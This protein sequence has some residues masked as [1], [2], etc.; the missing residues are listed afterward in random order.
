[1]LSSSCACF[2]PGNQV[3]NDRLVRQDE[4]LLLFVYPG[5]YITAMTRLPSPPTKGR[6]TPTT[7][8]P[9]NGPTE[10]GEVISWGSCPPGVTSLSLIPTG[11]RYEA[12]G[13]GDLCATNGSQAAPR[14][15]D[16]LPMPPIGSSAEEV[17]PCHRRPRLRTSTSMT[18]H[19]SW[20]NNSPL[21]GYYFFGKKNKTRTTP[22]ILFI[23]GLLSTHVFR[24]ITQSQ[25]GAKSTA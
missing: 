8:E 15:D 20:L 25:T 23:S 7:L 16:V 19:P 24:L 17:V 5:Y 11:G 6:R 2:A 22:D 12:E 1:M 13:Q 10:R 14:Q 21:V 4:P 9:T 3:I 18:D